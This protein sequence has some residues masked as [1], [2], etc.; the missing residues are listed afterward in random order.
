MGCINI[1]PTVYTPLDF[2]ASCEAAEIDKRIRSSIKSIRLSV[3]AMGLGLARIKTRQLY[4][5]LGYDS[6]AH[7]IQK[8]CDDT[9]MDRTNIYKWLYIGKAYLKYQNDLEQIGFNDSDGPTKLPYL[10]RALEANQK[11]EVFE[12]VKIMSF[13]EF[14]AFSK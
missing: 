1:K 6:I 11:K 9:K 13:R 2:T 3:L 8:L 7:Y 5:E 10:E 4:K 14:V 12:K